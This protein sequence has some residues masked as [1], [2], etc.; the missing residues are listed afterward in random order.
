MTDAEVIEQAARD[1]HV[2]IERELDDDLSMWGWVGD[3]LSPGW[4]PT[5]SLAINQMREHLLRC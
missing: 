3:D 5:R 2:L 1:G 4:W